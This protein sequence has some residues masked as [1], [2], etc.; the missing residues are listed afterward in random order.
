MITLVFS[1]LLAN[2]AMGT[3]V[4]SKDQTDFYKQ[5]GTL[6]SG[7]ESGWVTVD[8]IA[9]HGTDKD[10]NK[11]FYQLVFMKGRSRDLIDPTD[12]LVVWL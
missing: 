12:P 4:D 7:V 5:F 11:F 3:S 9:P 2:Q 1:L 6:D 8:S 10:V